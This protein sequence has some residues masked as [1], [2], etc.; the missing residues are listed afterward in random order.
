M[1]ESPRRSLRS[2]PK[3]HLHLH[4]EAAVREL[5]LREM[6]HAIGI[7]I[8]PVQN[9]QDFG[10]FAGYYQGL[11]AVLADPKNLA[12]LFRELAEDAADEGVVYVE[13]AVCPQF[14]VSTFGSIDS[15]LEFMIAEA[16]RASTATG[17]EIGLMVTADR[18]A[19]VDEAE[20]LATLAA[21]HSGAGVTA[22]G[23]ANDEAAFPGEPFENAFTIAHTAGL[24]CAPHAGELN[25]P[26]AIDHAVTRLHAVRVQ[27]GITA[28][29]DH[30]LIARLRDA[31]VCFDIC[32]TS[33]VLLSLVANIEEHPLPRMLD[34]GLRCSINADDPVIFRT[35]ILNEYELC[36]DS[37]GLTDPQLADCA[38]NSIAFSSA[39]AARKQ[40]AFT[41]IDSWL[42][43][44][45]TE[46]LVPISRATR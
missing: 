30:T 43:P 13:V 38:R 44:A 39:T 15:S 14:Y 1:S 5:S 35:S 17:V 37:L 10:E 16:G 34:A 36:R 25:G 41:Q 18:A 6:G 40:H 28:L 20:Y 29:A 2:L 8:S 22:F 33:N 23:L 12:R 3:A 45:L 21:R 46:N 7:A 32:P 42:G 24:V 4:L 9:F 11:L 27:H 19:P 31:P 26:E